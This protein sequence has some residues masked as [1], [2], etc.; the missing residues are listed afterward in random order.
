MM[1]C[2]SKQ[3]ISVM[4]VLIVS[5]NML[6]KYGSSKLNIIS[7]HLPLIASQIY[8]LM[9]NSTLDSSIGFIGHSTI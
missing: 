3:I 2:H 7:L 5:H 6:G 8:F 9:L 1:S 4:F